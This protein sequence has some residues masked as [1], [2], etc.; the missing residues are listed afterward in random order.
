MIILEVKGDGAKPAKQAPSEKSLLPATALAALT[1]LQTLSV[2]SAK[3]R[4]RM[5]WFTEI[6]GEIHHA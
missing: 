2:R 5:Q 4:G 1:D 3:A 6:L